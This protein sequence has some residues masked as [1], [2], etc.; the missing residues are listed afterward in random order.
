MM[1]CTS[2]SSAG[3]EVTVQGR[4]SS[5]QWTSAVHWKMIYVDGAAGGPDSPG[6]DLVVTTVRSDD[7]DRAA[8]D[9]LR[10]ERRAAW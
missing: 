2:Y 5:M 3:C 1:E 6:L 10:H 7:G 9:Y 4:T 8:C